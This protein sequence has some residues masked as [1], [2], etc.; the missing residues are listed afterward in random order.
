MLNIGEIDMALNK[1]KGNMYT[2]CACGCGNEIPFCDARGRMRKYVI[3]HSRKGKCLSL[4]QRFWTKVD[5][6]KSDSCWLWS[7]YK[8]KDGYGHIKLPGRNGALKSAHRISWQLTFGN[9]PH[10]VNVCHTCDN[11]SCVNPAHLF[12]GSDT[13]NMQD[14]LAK[15][16]LRSKLNQ[17]M[18]SDIRK[19][20]KN[21][22]LQRRLAEEY[23][24]TQG[25]I[26][27][28]VNRES[29]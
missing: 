18:A 20:Y 29:W 14:A 9:I 5:K 26:S 1:Q 13:D 12:L 8:S 23:G 6:T 19:K 21:G 28:I 22:I 7:A 17:E 24:V 4:A 3:G 16:R 10:G 25:Q 27:R 11:P 2:Q 15:N